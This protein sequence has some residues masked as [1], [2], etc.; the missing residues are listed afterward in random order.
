MFRA[1]AQQGVESSNSKACWL[2]VIT[3]FK[4]SLFLYREILSPRCWSYSTFTE[5]GCWGNQQSPSECNQNPHHAGWATR[6]PQDT[7]RTHRYISAVSEWSLWGSEKSCQN[8]YQCHQM[9]TFLK[10]WCFIEIY[11]PLLLSGCK[12]CMIIWD[13]QKQNS[14]P[15][16]LW[17]S[18]SWKV[19]CQQFHMYIAGHEQNNLE[20]EKLGSLEFSTRSF[21]PELSRLSCDTRN[22][23]FCFLHNVLSF[24]FFFNLSLSNINQ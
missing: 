17:I 10:T 15:W 4:A 21:F 24:L 16:L 6:G 9:E 22:Q 14:L 18:S 5:V 7:P 3:H 19:I 1:V 11:C 12:S 8:C 20:K 13:L 2:C 23:S